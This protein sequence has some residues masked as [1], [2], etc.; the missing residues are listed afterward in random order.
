MATKVT[1]L[2]ELTTAPDS[3]DVLH[4]VDVDDTT[5]GAAGTSKKIQVSNLG[6]TGTVTSVD[7]AGGTGLS[8]SGGPITG[9]GTITVDLDNTAVTPGSYTSADIT[10]DAQGRVT[11]A[12]NG[13]GGGGGGGVFLRANWNGRAEWGTTEVGAT[14]W[15]LMSGFYGQN[16]F[17][18]STVISATLGTDPPTVGTTSISIPEREFAKASFIQVGGGTSGT[19]KL[20]GFCDWTAV[21][22]G[23]AGQT[24]DIM[25]VTTDAIN[26]DGTFNGNVTCRVVLFG[27]VVC[28]SSIANISPTHF[29]FTGHNAMRDGSAVM[30]L[31]RWSSATFTA[32]QQVIFSL[33]AIIS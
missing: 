25:G 31:A 12:A 27:Q 22:G 17:T 6:G 8:S 15:C 29:D 14:K 33:Q 20:T 5:G 18:W 3:S 26:L 19:L 2:T 11:A 16:Y 21:T 23:A 30:F 24:L 32:Q 4:I 7:V 10:V 9:S 13:S 1:D 28:P